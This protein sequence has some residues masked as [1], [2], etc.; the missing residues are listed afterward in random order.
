MIELPG[1]S[2]NVG[3]TTVSMEGKEVETAPMEKSRSRKQKYRKVE[4]WKV[5][6]IAMKGKKVEGQ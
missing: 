6:E 3:N 5:E 4:V 2:V 1:S